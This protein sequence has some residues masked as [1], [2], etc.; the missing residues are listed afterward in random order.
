MES[1]YMDIGEALSKLNE[2]KEAFDADL[3]DEETFNSQ[4]SKIQQ[5]L[6]IDPRD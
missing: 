4:K 2:L 5:K 3:I 1:D 6:K